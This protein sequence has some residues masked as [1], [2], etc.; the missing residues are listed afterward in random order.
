[1]N[2][3]PGWTIGR[4]W[5]GYHGDDGGF[6][7][8]DYPKVTRDTYGSGDVV[9]CGVDEHGGIFFTKNGKKQGTSLGIIR[10]VQIQRN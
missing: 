6:F 5:W 8:S 2:A 1:L 7:D 9:G 3:G 4:Y 10:N